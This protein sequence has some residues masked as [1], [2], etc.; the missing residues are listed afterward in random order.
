MES[1]SG[2]PWDAVICGTGLQQSLLALSKKR[3]LHLD[4]NDYYGQHEAAFT[5]QEAES[6]V[7]ANEGQTV[8]EVAEVERTA[9][10]VKEPL[11][12][13]AD[14]AMKAGEADA[15]APNGIFRNAAIWRHPEA[16]A[17]GLSYPRAYSL[18][19]A[20]QIVHTR[21]KLL[22]QLVSSRA[23]RQVEFLAVGSF[24]VYEPANGDLDT[25]LSRIPS[26][27]EDVF[28]S[29]SISAKSKRSLMKFLKFVVDFDSD[30]QADMWKTQADGALVDFLIS[31]FKLDVDLRKYIL[32]LTLTLDDKVN[33][34]DGLTTI[35]RH[36]TSMGLFGPGFCAVYPKWGGM[37]EV[38]QVGCRAGAVGGGTY[39][40]N[41]SMKLSTTSPADKISLDL[42][43]GATVQTSTL[44]SSQGA[45]SG[46]GR[47]SRLVAV[48]NSPLESLFEVVVEG[49]PTPAVSVIAFPSGTILPAGSKLGTPIYAMVHSSET[50]ECPKGQCVIYLTTLASLGSKQRLE[51][52][53]ESLSNIADIQ[54]TPSCLY[55]LYY[56]QTISERNSTTD[57]IG[58]SRR[59]SFPSPSLSLAFDDADLDA[60]KEA[61]QIVMREDTSAEE[62]LVFEDREGADADH[63]MY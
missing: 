11:E 62:Y 26:S 56:E 44:I 9:S 21:S 43:N 17:S 27:R 1:L 30:E 18:A 63:D 8:S 53:V 33:V 5:L 40:L 41:T 13:S 14:A 38:A 42:S 24:H 35:N 36:L 59:F 20:P 55:Q 28:S 19:L 16:E 39:M 37:S 61:W 12:T 48:V 58:S 51:Q 2:E 22:S 29:R 50:G 52:A 23:Y 46:T 45:P 32:A 34:R 57:T 6:W 60:V 3:V 49:A 47:I 54:E 10:G 15:M 25:R 7:K 4:P 31:Q